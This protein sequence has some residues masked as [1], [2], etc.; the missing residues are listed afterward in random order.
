MTLAFWL[1]LIEDLLSSGR[2]RL[3]QYRCIPLHF[4]DA[5]L[6]VAHT[7][8]ALSHLCADAGVSWQ[9]KRKP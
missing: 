8:T 6:L 7:Y 4:T 2:R 1:P 5:M 3:W 9:R